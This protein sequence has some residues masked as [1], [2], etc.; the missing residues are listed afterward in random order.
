MSYKEWVDNP[1][2]K[3]SNIFLVI[4]IAIGLYFV[5]QHVNHDPHA[6][7]KWNPA[8]NPSY[9]ND[10]ELYEYVARQ[11]DLVNKHNQYELK[12]GF[13]P[14]NQTIS[15]CGVPDNLQTIKWWWMNDTLI[16][17]DCGNRT[18]GHRI[19]YPPAD[20]PLGKTGA[21]Y[22]VTNGCAYEG[23][24]YDSLFVGA[25][26]CHMAA[27]RPHPNFHIIRKSNV[28]WNNDTQKKELI[29]TANATLPNGTL[30]ALND[31]RVSFLTKGKGC[32]FTTLSESKILFSYDSDSGD[33]ECWK[34]V[35]GIRNPCHGYFCSIIEWRCANPKCSVALSW[36]WTHPVINNQNITSLW[37][38]RHPAHRWEWRY[39]F[40]VY[41]LDELNGQKSAPQ[42][43][44]F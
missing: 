33:K 31:S 11:V 3:W 30:L 2:S 13:V 8:N 32:N 37:L 38:V 21:G 4:L 19:H 16:K 18:W 20:H 29:L 7:F 6:K 26:F 17:D 15:L 42:K 9:P 27:P 24:E 1:P 25:K 44:D 12:N 5:Y 28:T 10:T 35:V 41:S 36:N 34:E 40:T 23:V 43:V 14:L 22:A 39:N